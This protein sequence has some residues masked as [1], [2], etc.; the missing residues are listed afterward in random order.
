MVEILHFALRKQMSE[1]EQAAFDPSQS[2]AV[3]HNKK[4]P[5]LPPPDSLFL[6]DLLSIVPQ[7]LGDLKA[8]VDTH[9]AVKDEVAV[10][11]FV[12]GFVPGLV[13]S[14]ETRLPLLNKFSIHTGAQT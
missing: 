2:I 6:K 14:H 9:Y 11:W 13:A 4:E 3:N 10:E 5:P 12:E 7:T 1:P 8:L